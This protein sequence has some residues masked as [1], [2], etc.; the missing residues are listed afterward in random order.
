MIKTEVSFF[1]YQSYQL[2]ALKSVFFWASKVFKFDPC[3]NDQC[4]KKYHLVRVCEICD[5]AIAINCD[6]NCNN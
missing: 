1:F 5:N 2:S 4:G 6:K 3:F